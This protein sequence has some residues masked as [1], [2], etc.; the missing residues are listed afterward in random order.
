MSMHFHPAKSEVI[1]LSFHTGELMIVKRA[2]GNCQPKTKRKEN[3]NSPTPIF[4]MFSLFCLVYHF[5]LITFSLDVLFLPVSLLTSLT[6]KFDV[7][8]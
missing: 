2:L 6:C 7:F 4:M 8:S 3:E 1:V 5:N